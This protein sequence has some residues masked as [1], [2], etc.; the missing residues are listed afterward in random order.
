MLFILT[1]AARADEQHT[2]TLET[3]I[4]TTPLP[5]ST[6]NTALP[7][8]VLSGEQLRL[9]VGSTLGETLQQEPGIT[10]Q[11]FGP[12]VGQPVIRGQ[13]GSRVLVLQNGLGSLDA[14]SQSPDHANSTE[15][16]WAE[17]IEVL[18]GPAALLYGSGAIGGVVNVIDNRVPSYIPD[19]L[20]EAT[21]EQRYNTVNNGKN[22]AFKLDGGKGNI[23]FHVDGF[24]RDSGNLEIPGLA[25]DETA[26]ADTHAD[27]D[28]DEDHD[29]EVQNSHKKLLNSDTESL[30]GT[31]GLSWVGDDGFIG[32]SVNHLKNEYGIPPG[33]HGHG[34][35]E[36]EHDNEDE[37]EHEDEEVENVRID[38]RQTRY[39]LKG[40]LA[41]PYQ[42]VNKIKLRLGYNDYQHIEKENGER[43]TTFDN[44]GFASRVELLQ[45]AWW[46]FDHGVVGFQTRNNTFSA[47]GEEA[48]VP[49]SDV[50]SFGIF[51]LED[52]HFNNVT[53]EFG[54]RVEQQW[55]KPKG[56]RERSHTPVSGSLS[57]LWYVTDTDS[58]SLSF[59][60]SQR[61]PDIQELFANGPHLSTSSFELGDNTLSEE[62]SHN[63]ELGI[64]INRDWMQAE[65]NLFQNWVDNYISQLNTGR[66]FDD[67]SGQI[68]DRC[69]TLDCL[70]VL[71]ATQRDTQLRGFEGQVTIPLWNF[72][73]GTLE[74]RLF[75]DFVRAEFSDKSGG[76]VPRMPPLRFGGQLGWKAPNWG[77]NLRATRAQR[78]NNPGTNETPTGGYL[79]FNVNANYRLDFGAHSSMLLFAKGT[80]LLNDEIRYST[81]FLRNFAPQAGRGVELGLRLEF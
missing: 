51:M 53:L 41:L 13:T 11:S 76:D 19:Q 34:E 25:I 35:E 81:S 71:Q 65:L 12:G 70:P 38:L 22:T 74:S 45:N 78:Q 55:I 5:Q 73:S 15:A 18:R 79:A 26:E 21:V 50:D 56:M 64:R 52:I 2:E 32:V 59:S 47:L 16:L 69:P 43:G 27:D 10:S 36:D 67:A 30:S 57:A 58:L 3:M 6:E 33:A 40:E 8:T 80:N 77:I 66:F 1:A 75:A 60:R 23:A 42:F 24:Y 63:I 61:A 44:R 68:V 17:R 28:V 62:T 9:Q 4:I 14:S 29:E 72:E 37:A 46:L 7:V 54:V 48:F 39:D 49:K 20:I 31:L